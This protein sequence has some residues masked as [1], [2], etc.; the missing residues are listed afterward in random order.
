MAKSCYR[1]VNEILT[2][3]VGWIARSEHD[4]AH[5]H[6]T[7]IDVP[8][9]LGGIGR[10]AAGELGHDR[11]KRGKGGPAIG[12]GGSCAPRASAHR[13]HE[14]ISSEAVQMSFVESLTKTDTGSVQKMKMS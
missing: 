2:A 1:K 4:R 6:V 8:A 10:A 5:A 12:V 3:G 9:F 14:F 11:L 7:V 13:I